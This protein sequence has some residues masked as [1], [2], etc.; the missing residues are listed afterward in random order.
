MTRF[1]LRS[2]QAARAAACALLVI[3]AQGQ[4]NHP[5]S[6][7]IRNPQ[8][9]IRDRAP[10]DLTLREA[11]AGQ[12]PVGVA[13]DGFLPD[14][15]KPNELDLILRQFVTLTPA[16]C[17][18]VAHVQ[19]VEGQFDFRLADAFVTF[20]ARNQ[21][22][23]C[24]HCLV[25]AKDDRTPTWF[26]KD[27]DKPASRDL[28]LQRMKTHIQTVAGRYRGKVLSWD[29]VNEALDDGAGFIRPSSWLTITG[30]DF[31]ASAF[32][33]A[34]QT[35][36]DAMLI[37]NDYNIEQPAKREKLLRLLAGLLEKKAPIHAV[38][39]QGHYEID[40]VP[41]RDIEDTIIAIRRLG[42]KVLITELDIDVIPRSRW[43]A[44]DGKRRDELAR[45]N[46]FT[47]GCPAAVLERQAAQYGRLFQIF[48]SHADTIARVTFW[49]L[50]DGRSWLNNFPWRRVN[51]PLLFD[52]AGAPKPAFDAVLSAA[53][54]PI[55]SPVPRQGP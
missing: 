17:M 19:Q 26:Y 22:K 51:Y 34:H 31:L 24:G 53:R 30:E 20:A 7:E 32:E 8:S 29:V 10:G 38:G 5:A 46:P 50:H 28:L 21:I 39:I 35:D 54:V 18:K 16:N 15:Y 44:D 11:F 55:A 37:Y 43:W 41:Y 23:V 36:P 3:L 47:N 42:L 4:D 45:F 49:D 48:R 14:D 27:G 1:Q 52:R 9:A 13:L 2:Q 12:F 40:A 33:F 25:W 6:A